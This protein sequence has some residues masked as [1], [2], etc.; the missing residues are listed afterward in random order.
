MKEQEKMP[1]MT[2]EEV[3]DM[4]I[5][6]DVDGKDAMVEQEITLDSISMGIS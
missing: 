4:E 6:Q 3:E 2:E 1:E 5:D